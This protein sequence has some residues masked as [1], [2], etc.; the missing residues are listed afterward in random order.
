MRLY[1]RLY[2]FRLRFIFCCSNIVQVFQLADNQFTIPIQII[3]AWYGIVVVFIAL[4]KKMSKNPWEK[5]GNCHQ[6][7]KILQTFPLKSIKSVTARA[8]H[9]FAVVVRF[10]EN[11]H[12]NSFRKSSAIHLFCVHIK[13]AKSCQKCMQILVRV[14]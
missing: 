3:Y 1:C 10:M 2:F 7:N 13:L 12:I 9:N 4:R 14:R 11:I 6:I 5:I 8:H